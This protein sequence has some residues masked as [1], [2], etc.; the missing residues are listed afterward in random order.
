MKIIAPLA[1][2][3]FLAVLCTCSRDLKHPAPTQPL[4]TSGT[5]NPVIG[6]WSGPLPDSTYP[7]LYMTLNADSSYLL[8]VT[9]H[10]GVA[11]DT[12]FWHQ[13]TWSQVDTTARFYGTTCKKDSLAILISYPCEPV[14]V[15]AEHLQPVNDKPNQKWA[16]KISDMASIL[17]GLG[18]SQ[19]TI[20]LLMDA[21]IAIT[22]S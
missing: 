20:N 18:I 11:L 17:L 21:S 7:Y 14:I 16:I 19:S 12:I 1:I 6:T 13:G 5:V 9:A 10:S 4:G 2:V 22:K 15:L 8:Y 3:L